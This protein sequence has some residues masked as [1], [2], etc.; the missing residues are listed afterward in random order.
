M[1]SRVQRDGPIV[2]WEDD[3]APVVRILGASLSR[4]ATQPAVAEQ[5]RR[6]RGRV[7]LRSTVGPQAATIDFAGGVVHVTHGVTK[8]VDVLIEADLDTMGRPGAP[9][10]KLSG[11]A[12]HP[13]F[14]MRVGKVLDAPTPGGWRGAVDAMWSWAEG[15][16]GLPRLLRVV[17]SD[18]GAEHV[19]GEPDGTRV[20]VYGPGW[21]LLGVFT[22]ADHVGAAALEGRVQVVADFPVLSRFVGVMTRFMLG[23]GGAR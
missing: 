4:A 22:G 2:T 11:V 7:G 13:L 21:A 9:K 15:Q 8:D 14:A 23:E 6:L 18:D 19:V 12:R 3:A 20:E 17:C 1:I 16:E 10:P 5:M